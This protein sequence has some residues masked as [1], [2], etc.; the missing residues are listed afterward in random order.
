MKAFPFSFLYL[1]CFEPISKI[2]KKHT[3]RI[4]DRQEIDQEE[5]NRV[6]KLPFTSLASSTAIG[7]TDALA[8]TRRKKK[9]NR[10]EA[11]I[12]LLGERIQLS[13][14]MQEKLLNQMPADPRAAERRQRAQWSTTLYGP[15]SRRNL[16]NWL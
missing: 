8:A 7:D 9:T 4:P 15:S 2:S 6:E 11:F 16:F 3:E 14:Q 13:N 5:E 12:Q 1:F 10:E